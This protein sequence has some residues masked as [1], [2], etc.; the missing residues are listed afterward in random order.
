MLENRRILLIIGGGIAA[1]KTLDLVRRL[2]QRG[3]QVRAILT[4]AGAEFVTPL[5]V[6]SLTGDK[7]YQDLFDLTEEAEIGHIQLSR[8]ADLLVVAPATADLLAKMAA[9]LAGDLATTVLMA[10]DKPV[11]IAPA[12]NVRMWQHPATRRNVATLL[13]DGVFCVGPNDGDMA[14]GEYGPGRMAEPLEIVDAIV[15]H[16][17]DG[18]ITPFP[19]TDEQ[20]S[21]EKSHPLANPRPLTNQRVLITA[22]PTHE[23]I[24]PVRYIANRSSGK[25]GFAMARAV[26]ELGAETILVTGP[27]ALADPPGIETIRVETAQEMLHACQSQLPVDVAICVAAVG[28]WRSRQKAP[29]KIKK[30]AGLPPTMSL[31]ENPDILRELSERKNN[32]PKLVIGFAAETQDVVDQAKKKLKRKGCDWMIANDVSP[33]TGIIGGEE[34]AVHFIVGNIVGNTARYDVEN[35]PRMTKDHVARKLARRIVEHMTS[36][37]ITSAPFGRKRGGMNG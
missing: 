12:M 21:T 10:T 11:M 16:F 28:D 29:E 24:D 23:P 30:T 1:Y 14:C 8:D 15:K 22:G 31:T 4:R 32:R 33:E 9:G 5:S 37:T 20:R 6:S 35:W 18:R 19:E 2:R 7:V 17:S 34:N 3:A 13:N 36:G 27:V 26:A 25:Q